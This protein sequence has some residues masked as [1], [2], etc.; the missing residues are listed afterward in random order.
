MPKRPIFWYV[1]T[2][3]VFTKIIKSWTKVRC[4]PYDEFH[5]YKIKLYPK[6]Q[7]N[8]IANVNIRTSW[9]RLPVFVLNQFC[10][11]RSTNSKV[12][13]MLWVQLQV[14]AEGKMNCLYTVVS[15]VFRSKMWFISIHIQA[16]FCHFDHH[17]QNPNKFQINSNHSLWLRSYQTRHENLFNRNNDELINRLIRRKPKYREISTSK[18]VL[19][20]PK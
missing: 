9:I 5:R 19:C 3:E 1:R 17:W 18:V 7:R 11:W 10:W 6:S 4:L 20:E 8:A 14:H 2:D 13:R 15:L 16:N 12:V